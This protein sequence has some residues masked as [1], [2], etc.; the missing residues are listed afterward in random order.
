MS[1]GSTYNKQIGITLGN[2]YQSSKKNPY[3]S[4]KNSSRSYNQIGISSNSKSSDT[5]T[6]TET[7]D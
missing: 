7:K 3:G 5:K 2:S 6:V 1:E 4:N